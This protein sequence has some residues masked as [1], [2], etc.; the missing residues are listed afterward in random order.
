MPTP[1]STSA[2]VLSPAPIDTSLFHTHFNLQNVLRTKHKRGWMYRL[3]FR[4]PTCYDRVELAMQQMCR[5]DGVEFIRVIDDNGQTEGKI[6]M[7]DCMG[8]DCVKKRKAEEAVLAKNV[9]QDVGFRRPQPIK[10]SQHN[11]IG[12]SP[13]HNEGAR[14][15]SRS[16]IKKALNANALRKAMIDKQ[17]NK[18]S[19][20]DFMK[21]S[22]QRPVDRSKIHNTIISVQNSI[23]PTLQIDSQHNPIASLQNVTDPSKFQNPIDSSH[24]TSSPTI[25]AT[26]S[27]T[28]THCT[29]IN[30]LMATIAAKD[31]TIR[32]QA[33]LIEQLMG[34]K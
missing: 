12:P 7:G 4:T 26:A 5:D 34:R 33:M 15:L 9:R 29:T 27:A 11:T 10:P 32:A 25:D 13:E 30:A 8:D 16:E 20:A 24:S 6:S 23:N 22:F 31:Q 1:S 28:T 18:T 2:T 17:R 21:S 19:F 3:E 14:I